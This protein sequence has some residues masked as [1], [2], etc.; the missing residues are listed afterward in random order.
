MASLLFVLAIAL[1]VGSLAYG[2]RDG[3]PS[4]ALDWLFGLQLIRAA[5]AFAIIAVLITVIVRGWG[6]LWPTSFLTTGFGYPAE[7][8]V[9][10]GVASSTA[11]AL[12]V[13]RE[14]QDAIRTLEVR[15]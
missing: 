3:L 6:G 8:E 4:I 11:I 1:L 13:R 14:I 12:E 10:G 9:E 2:V 7:Q 15:E 5:L